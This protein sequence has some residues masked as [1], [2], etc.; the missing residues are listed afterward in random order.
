MGSKIISFIY[1][2]WKEYVHRF[3]AEMFGVC[4]NLS[5]GIIL[6]ITSPNPS[7]FTIFLLFLIGGVLLLSGAIARNSIAL[8]C[9]YSFY[10][11]IDSLGLYR[12]L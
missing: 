2:D 5:G 9:L 10:L 7:L 4:F 1:I 3:V 6:A 12:S 8:T 11:F